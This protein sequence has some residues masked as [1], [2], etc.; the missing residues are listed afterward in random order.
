MFEIIAQWQRTTCPTCGMPNGDPSP[1]IRAAQIVLDRTGFGPS[2]HLSLQQQ[3]PPPEYSSD[4]EM[5]EQMQAKVDRI[6]LQL[7]L[8]RNQRQLD[9]DVEEGFIVPD[10]DDSDAKE[11]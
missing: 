4:D 9:A 2:A 11:L 6:Q 8:L 7:N 3:P 10:A 1:V 5:I